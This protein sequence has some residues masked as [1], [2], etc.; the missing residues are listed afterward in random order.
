MDISNAGQ[1]D[2]GAPGLLATIA[3]PGVVNALPDGLIPVRFTFFPLQIDIVEPW[4]ALPVAG[5]SAFVIFIWDVDGAAPTELPPIELRGP[6]T[7]ADFPYRVEI[8]ESW[9]LSSAVVNL[10]FRVHNVRPDSPTF[11]LSDSVRITIDHDA[12][13]RSRELDPAIFPEDPI[14]EGYL[15]ATPLVPIEIPDTYFD[16]KVGDEVLIY[17]SDRD[18]LP[19]GAPTLISSPLP[20]DTG[21]IYV[22]VPRDFFRRFPGARRLYCF[23]RLRDRAGNLNLA[24]SRVAEVE[25]LLTTPPSDL[26]APQVPAYDADLLID[27]ADARRIVTVRV[28]TEYLDWNPGDQCYVEWDGILLPPVEV[29]TFP[30]SVPVSWS[31]LIANGADLR[32]LVNVGVRYF[33]RRAGD[34]VGPGEVSP[35]TLVTVDMT[36]AGQDHVDAPALLNR[37]LALVDVFGR[38]SNTANFLDSRDSIG[39]VRVTFPLFNNPQVGEVAYLYW[40]SRLDPVATY[41]VKPGDVGGTTVTFDNE[42]DWQVIVDGGTNARTLVHYR[43]SNFVNEQLSPD[44]VVS[45]NV[46][47]P[48]SYLRP[49]F[50]QSTEATR[51]VLTCATQPP[52]WEGVQVLVSDPRIQHGDLVRLSWQ[53]YR[54]SPDIDPDPDTAETFDHTWD[55]VADAAG[56]TFLVLPYEQ[57]IKPL[58]VNA[59]AEARYT[60]FRGG[61]PTGTSASR[62]VQVDRQVN[63]TPP[64]PTFCGPD[65]TGP[66]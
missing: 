65:G 9:L 54:Q 19:T 33:I 31:V 4:A 39:P 55:E 59:G 62:F 21:P 7:R 16:R 29:V 30:F 25:L 58:K 43:T 41:T 57:L 8:P 10:S 53:G 32:R 5:F 24:F 50:P 66:E 6:I 2:G 17:L 40:P 18:A 35:W 13:G 49:S 28:P 60:V 22:D 44:Q 51:F 20:T 36:I 26:P 11:D 63:S 27:R 52:I 61:I 14:T 64:N 46:A 48:I 47:P 56:Y 12:P 38:V 3:A 15:N 1:S 45:V 42:V 23:Y 37:T 34:T